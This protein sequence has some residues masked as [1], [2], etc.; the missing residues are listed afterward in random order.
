MFKLTITKEGKHKDIECATLQQTT[1]ELVLAT[2]IAAKKFTD[3]TAVRYEV[4]DPHGKVILNRMH[5]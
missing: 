5:N 2:Q 1:L 3:L 4:R